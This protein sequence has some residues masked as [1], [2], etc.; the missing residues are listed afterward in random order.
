MNLEKGTEWQAMAFAEA[1]KAVAEEAETP[2]SVA[3][4]WGVHD[5]LAMLADGERE[6]FAGT[7]MARIREKYSESL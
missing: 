6:P 2:A 5:M 4:C 3:Y 7:L 1:A